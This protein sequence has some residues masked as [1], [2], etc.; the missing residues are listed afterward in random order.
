MCESILLVPVLRYD[1]E[2]ML[3]KEKEISMIRP[4]QMDNL[5]SLLGIRSRIKSECTDKGVML[6]E[7][8]GR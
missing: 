4:V 8:G 1:S 6:S 5:R 3:W 7:E 2:T